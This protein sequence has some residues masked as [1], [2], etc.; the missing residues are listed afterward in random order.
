MLNPLEH[1]KEDHKDLV[2]QIMTVILDAIVRKTHVMTQHK[3]HVL[4]EVLL[5]MQLKIAFVDVMA[6]HTTTIAK[7]PNRE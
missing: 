3:V 4:N 2:N 7:Q 5:V 1:A 6:K